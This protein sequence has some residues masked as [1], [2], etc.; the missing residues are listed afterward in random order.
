MEIVIW[1]AILGR[2]LCDGAGEADA[3]VELDPSLA[4]RLDG[5]RGGSG[6]HVDGYAL[7]CL[8]EL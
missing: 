8:A 1:R 6:L 4:T 3:S 7:N 5:H 2:L